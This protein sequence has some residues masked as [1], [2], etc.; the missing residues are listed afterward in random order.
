[1]KLM[2]LQLKDSGAWRNVLSFDVARTA[3]VETAAAALLGATG[4]VS[5]V[6]RVL[7]G[8][9]VIAYC[10]QPDSVWRAA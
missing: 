1:M 3:Q 5:T 9:L 2:K 4:G 6:M 10:A 8:D 7:D